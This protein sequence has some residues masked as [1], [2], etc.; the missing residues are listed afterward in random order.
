MKKSTICIVASLLPLVACSDQANID[1]F[2][3]C[4]VLEE[5]SYHKIYQ[6]P[7]D[8][9]WI[10][11]LKQNKP[12]G[13]FRSNFDSDKNVFNLVLNDTEHEYIEVAFDD[14]GICDENQTTVRV[15]ISQPSDDK[16]WAF[17]G[18]K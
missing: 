13:M 16:L 11:D 17:V 3:S 18:C 1:V 9:S 8:T 2:E 5:N 14:V 6:C 10:V 4:S 15:K 12:N 7:P